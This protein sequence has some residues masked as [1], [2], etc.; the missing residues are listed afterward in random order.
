MM[1]SDNPRRVALR[2]ARI[3]ALGPI[4]PWWRVFARRRW[5]QSA[6]SIN[7]MDVSEYAAWIARH[8]DE[9]SIIQLA[10]RPLLTLRKDPS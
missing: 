2:A 5:R 4:P 7:A 10:N 3:E 1:G 6:A 9:D 8:Y